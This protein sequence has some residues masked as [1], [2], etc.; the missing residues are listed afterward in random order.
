MILKNMLMPLSNECKSG[1][2]KHKK[3]ACG[4]C[5]HYHIGGKYQC[6]KINLNLT[7]CGCKKFT[8]AEKKYVI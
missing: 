2:C 7:T 8:K 6:C 4:H 5:S 3:C 1:K